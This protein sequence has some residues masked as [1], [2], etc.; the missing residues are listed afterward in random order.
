MITALT[1]HGHLVPAKVRSAYRLFALAK[2]DRRAR[3]L[4]DLSPLTPH[5]DPPACYLPRALDLLQSGRPRWGIKID[6]RNGFYYIPVDP[7]WDSF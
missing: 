3:I 6:L 4:Y 2:D 1:K 5:L 7:A